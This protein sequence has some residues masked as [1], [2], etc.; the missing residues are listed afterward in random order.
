MPVSEAT[1]GSGDISMCRG[2]NEMFPVGKNTRNRVF[3]FEES[4]SLEKGNL[5]KGIFMVSGLT[6][7]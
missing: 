2:G 1:R 7:K 3:F 5:L 6:L 4:E